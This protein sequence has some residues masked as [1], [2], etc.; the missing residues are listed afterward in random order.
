MAIDR[1]INNSQGQNYVNGSSG[2]KK[3]PDSSKLQHV[4]IVFLDDS[5][6][7]GCI[8]SKEIPENKIMRIKFS[9]NQRIQASLLVLLAA[10]NL[11]VYA[12]AFFGEK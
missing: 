6:K 10:I 3:K 12:I 9:V 2:K 4:D 1:N 11:I 7:V 8:E 5:D